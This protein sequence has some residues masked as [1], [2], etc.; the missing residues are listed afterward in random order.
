ML[1]PNWPFVKLAGEG[2][3]GRLVSN[4]GPTDSVLDNS[5]ISIST[6]SSDCQIIEGSI[7]SVSSEAESNNSTTPPL[8]VSSNRSQLAKNSKTCYVQLERMSAETVKSLTTGPTTARS[9]NATST[10]AFR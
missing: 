8:P 7:V 9:M 10:F 1:D 3:L 2:E 6:D 5:I 4:P